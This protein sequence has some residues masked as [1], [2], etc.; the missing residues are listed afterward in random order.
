MAGAVAA[1]EPARPVDGGAGVGIGAGAQSEGLMAG[2]L[3]RFW[4][5]FP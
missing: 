1:A 2:G 5:R 4:E 3:I